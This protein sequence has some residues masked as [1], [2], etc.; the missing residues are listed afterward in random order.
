[1]KQQNIH[2]LLRFWGSPLFR[3]AVKNTFRLAL[4]L[5]LGEL[6]TILMGLA[7]TVMIGHL[8]ETE[9]A[10]YGVASVVFVLSMLVI[11]GGVRMVPTPVAEAHELRDGP[12]VRTLVHAGMWLSVFFMLVAIPLLWVG[13]ELFPM[14][15]Q[16]PQVTILAVEYLKVVAYSM[17]A[18][19]LFAILVNFADAFTYVRQTM[20]IS[21]GGLA[22]DI[23]LNWVLIFGKFGFPSLGINAVAISTGITHAVMSV[24]LILLIWRKKELRYFRECRTRLEEVWAQTRSFIR[25]GIPSALQIMVEFAAFGA[26]TILI[27]QISKTEQAAHQIA[28]NLISVTYVTMMGVSTAGMIRVGQALAYRSRV[29]V[30]MA[31]VSTISLSILLML[32]P[33]ALFLLLPGPIASFYTTDAQVMQIASGLLLYAGLFQM[34]DAAQLS[35][36]SMLR[37]LN[38]VKTPTLLSLLAFWVLGLPVGYWLA[39]HQGWNAKGIW[40]G[41]L[42]ALLAQAGLFMLRFF[43]LTGRVGRG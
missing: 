37:A 28:L 25:Y 42:I 30:W 36:I 24:L 33:T 3:P 41:Y 14:L 39:V 17:P 11:W 6:S 40:V 12:R 29:K 15:G 8:G 21:V 27:G 2:T 19:I 32:F 20:F 31:G 16:D 18:L 38:D 7:G 1:M 23:L 10:A 9:L 13:I 4:P 35:S 5:M 26:G 43:Q 22:L 34:A